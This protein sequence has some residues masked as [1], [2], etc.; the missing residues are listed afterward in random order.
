MIRRFRMKRK[1]DE[2]SDTDAKV[3]KKKVDKNEV[4]GKILKSHSYPWKK[5]V[6]LQLHL[7]SFLQKF[8]SYSF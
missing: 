8:S 4:S 5:W 3:G 1:S 2:K 6:N 7:P